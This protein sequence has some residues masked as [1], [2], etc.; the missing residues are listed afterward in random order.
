MAKGAR[1]GLRLLRPVRDQVEFQ[2]ACLD[3]L[4]GADHRARLVWAYVEG[5]DLSPLYEDVQAIEGE[6]GAPKTD[7]ALLMA[8]WLYATIEGVGS[9]RHVARL[10]ETDAAYRWIMG[11]V[12]TNHH[13]LSDFRTAA[14]PALDAALS[15]SIALLVQS[16]LV[17]LDAVAV[18]GMRVRA[19]AGTASFRREATLETL[20]AEAETH[21]AALRNE[22]DLDP[23]AS[24]TRLEARRL[25]AAQDRLAR[26][27][28]AQAQTRTIEAERVSEA[29]AQR[30]KKPKQSRRDDEEGPPASSTDPDAR[31]MRMADGGFRPAYNVQEMVA[32]AS[33]LVIGVAVISGGDRGRLGATAAEI[34]R[35]YGTRPTRLIADGGYDSKND[36]AAR[37]AEGIAVYCPPPK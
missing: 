3:E 8:V 27:E 26:I 33:G 30:R 15:D 22:L 2:M 17:T 34:E 1:P 11:G 10:I 19:S 5:L 28:A 7:P 32:P 4:I 14:G 18:D 37:E 6:A 12:G 23:A 31:I 9:A 24:K 13:T 20:R 29:V 35:R 16:G 36:I 21:V 25:S